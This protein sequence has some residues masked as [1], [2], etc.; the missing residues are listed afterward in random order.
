MSN[1]ESLKQY[2][3]MPFAKLI[4]SEDFA[5]LPAKQRFGYLFKNRFGATVL[6]F[7]AFAALIFGA[8]YLKDNVIKGLFTASP[9]DQASQ[10]V[11]TNLKSPASFRQIGGDVLWEGTTKDGNKAYV[12]SLQ[13]DAQNS[14]GASLRGCMYVAYAETND[15]KITWNQDYGVQ[16]YT[17]MPQLCDSSTPLNI[18]L[19][20]VKTLVDINFGKNQEKTTANTPTSSSNGNTVEAIFVSST[21]QRDFSTLVNFKKI[22]QGGVLEVFI[23]GED[24]KEF[25][26]LTAKLKGNEGRVFKLKINN[27][28]K[29]NL[30]LIDAEL[31][32]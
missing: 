13:F 8:I 23:S 14:F 5:N 4:F 2:D 30:I 15:R 12:V 31:K 17:N 10:I 7:M 9:V 27:E 21:P 29:D 6:M 26:A 28:D 22:D 16:D 11:K 20:M 3:E 24:A 1:N 18:K 25:D 19:G 32:K